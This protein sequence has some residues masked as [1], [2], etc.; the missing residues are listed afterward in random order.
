[1]FPSIAWRCGNAS[2]LKTGPTAGRKDPL[3]LQLDRPCQRFADRAQIFPLEETTMLQL[4]I[5]LLVIALVAALL[6]FGGVAGS[7]VGLAKIAFF[8]FL[9]F[10]VL[11]FLGYGYRR[12]SA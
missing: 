2:K 8:V 12:R 11:S 10:A 1:M 3:N 7:F 4:A 6:G 9:V 5:A